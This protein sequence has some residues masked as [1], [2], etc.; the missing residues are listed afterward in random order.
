MSLKTWNTYFKGIIFHLF[1]EIFF[2]KPG[3]LFANSLCFS[4]IPFFRF[5][6]S[7]ICFLLLKI[8]K[9]SGWQNL[10]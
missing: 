8:E 4:E 6:G 1:V 5:G 3:T 9:E 2:I 10:R 7:Q